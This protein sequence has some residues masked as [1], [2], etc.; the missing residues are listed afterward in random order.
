MSMQ[1][2]VKQSSIGL[3]PVQDRLAALRLSSGVRRSPKLASI[4]KRGKI[5]LG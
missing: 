1:T 2:P 4:Q 3:T 5:G